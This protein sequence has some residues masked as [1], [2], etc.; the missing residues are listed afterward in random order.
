MNIPDYQSLMLPLLEA[1]GDGRERLVRDV[2]EDIAAKFG[3]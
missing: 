2:R 3:L 1:L